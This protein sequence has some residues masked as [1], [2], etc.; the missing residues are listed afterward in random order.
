[1][2]VGKCAPSSP[3]RESDAIRDGFAPPE[4]VE[5]AASS[6]DRSLRQKETLTTL[7]LQGGFALGF[8]CQ[9]VKTEIPVKLALL[10]AKVN[11]H[12]RRLVE[13]NWARK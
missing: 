12:R 8:A 1:M 7:V 13:P 2:S 5:Q 6:A 3:R 9:R 11:E 4:M 10:G